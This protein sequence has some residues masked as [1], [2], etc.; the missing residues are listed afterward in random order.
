MNIFTAIRQG[1][2]KFVK[3]YIKDGGDIES[4]DYWG[5]T[6]IIYAI[7]DRIFE[8]HDKSNVQ[9]AK[10]LIDAGCNINKYIFEDSLYKTPLSYASDSCIKLMI[11][12]GCNIDATLHHDRTLLIEKASDISYLDNCDP[13]DTHM[14]QIV[15]TMGLLIE[16]GCKLDIRDKEGYNYKDYL[17]DTDYYLKHEE[18]IKCELAESFRIRYSK[19]SLIELCCHIVKSNKEIYKDRLYLLNRDVRKLIKLHDS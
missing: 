16:L 15:K 2:I 5:R 10:L 11:R 1:N 9:I 13:Y 12:S 19:S 14:D 8:S 17:Y 6:P 7:T 18:R 3:K 4:K